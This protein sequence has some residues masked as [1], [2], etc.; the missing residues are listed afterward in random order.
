M[1]VY[2][3]QK[4]LSG[5]QVVI[6]DNATDFI[7]RGR[8]FSNRSVFTLGTGNNYF[9]FTPDPNNKSTIS[10][11]LSVSVTNGPCILEYYVNHDYT[12]G[13]PFTIPLL[14]RNSLSDNT[15]EAVITQNPTGTNTGIA[16]SQILVGTSSTGFFSGPGGGTA[17]DDD[18]FIITSPILINLINNSGGSTT[19]G[20]V[21][22]FYE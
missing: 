18:L 4:S 20:L 19:A 3:L 6:T 8:V 7:F 10:K 13:T 22:T 16:I 5:N 11:P 15:T 1:G 21:L 14:N 9:L 17:S 12:G 2:L